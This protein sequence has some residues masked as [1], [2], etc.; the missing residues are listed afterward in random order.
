M[1]LSQQSRRPSADPTVSPQDVHVTVRGQLPDRIRRYAQDKVA[2][3]IN[4]HDGHVWAT[5]V[6][7]TTS[8]DPAVK[9]S[10]TVE[11]GSDINGRRVRA[12]VAAGIPTEAVDLAVDRWERRLVKAVDRSRHLRRPRA[13]RGAVPAEWHGDR[14]HQPQYQARAV[15]E[16]QVA[17]RKAFVL[18]PQSVQQ[19][20]DD[21]EMLGHSFYLFTD[22]STGRQAV[23]YRREDGRYAVMGTVVPPEASPPGEG[24]VIGPDAPVLTETA[25]KRRLDDGDE[26]FVFYREPVW[27]NGQV[28][29]R[30]YDGNYGLISSTSLPIR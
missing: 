13:T 24:V 25:A 5:H 10:C 21:M 29:Y 14:V 30:R 2:H 8:A 12:Q 4:R 27:R 17:R 9:R 22:C 6:V 16:R 23:V 1:T 26:P 3:K 28:M 7:I 11:V 19:S 18:V 20:I 15:A